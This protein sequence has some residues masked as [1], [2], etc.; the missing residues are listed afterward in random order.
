MLWLRWRE[1][2]TMMSHDDQGLHQTKFSQSA[3]ERF[4]SFRGV[5]DS[6]ILRPTL[7]SSLCNRAVGLLGRYGRALV[8]HGM[9]CD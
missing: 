9:V 6:W 7:A 8:G 4:C 3:F 1:V 5:A 2:G